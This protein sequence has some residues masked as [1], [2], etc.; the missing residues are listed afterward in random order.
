MQTLDF[1]L[2]VLPLGILVMTLI[3]VVLFIAR[4]QDIKQ[5]K[6]KNSIEKFSKEKEKK[7]SEFKNQQ[8]ELDKMLELN[9]LDQETYDRLS[10]LVKMNEKKLDETIETLI[11][12]ENEKNNPKK[13][14]DTSPSESEYEEIPEEIIEETPLTDNA[15]K[16]VES[17]TAK[18]ITSKINKKKHGR[19]A[20]AKTSVTG[21]NK[22]KKYYKKA[23]D[24]PFIII[25]DKDKSTK[26]EQEIEA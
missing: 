26:K 19:K 9:S 12:L 13:D 5:K 16:T 20:H 2:I 1:I 14:I 17:E 4:R 21:K 8:A 15:G 22:K 10:L 24:E 18:P 25:F 7:H 11:S 6:I 3:G 23:N